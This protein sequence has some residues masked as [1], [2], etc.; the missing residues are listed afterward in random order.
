M[1]D[2]LMVLSTY[3]VVMCPMPFAVIFLALWM[4]YVGTD[5]ACWCGSCMLMWMLHVGV[6]VVC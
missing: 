6:E 2:G 5:V 3:R 1:A 4:L